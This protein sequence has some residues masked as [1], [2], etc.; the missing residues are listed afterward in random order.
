MTSGRMLRPVLVCLFALSAAGCSVVEGDPHRFEK[1]AQGIADIPIDGRVLAPRTAADAGLRPALKVEV[2][3]PHAL[4]DARDGLMH[5]AVEGAAPTVAE[6][7]APL[8]V[9]AAVDRVEAGMA[10]VGARA[11]SL[12]PAVPTTDPR[13]TIQLGAYSSESSAM[14]AWRDLADGEARH[15][16]SDLQPRFERAEVK[17]RSVVRLKVSTPTDRIDAVCRATQ[18]DA[19]WCDVKA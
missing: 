17:G 12:R 11:A 2:L 10:D 15:E 14:A 4:W 1:L 18:I 5:S 3:D 16:L 13:R 9:R 7:A 8:I 6:A 19:P